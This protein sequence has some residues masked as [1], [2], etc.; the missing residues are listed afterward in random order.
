LNNQSDYYERWTHH[1]KRINID[2]RDG[3][4]RYVEASAPFGSISSLHN[5]NGGQFSNQPPSSPLSFFVTFDAQ[6]E[7]EHS[8]SLQNSVP[9]MPQ[10]S[11]HPCRS[12]VSLFRISEKGKPGISQWRGEP[13][14]AME[15]VLDVLVDLRLLRGSYHHPGIVADICYLKDGIQ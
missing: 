11:V 2:T 1:Q 5:S 9:N 13:A 12:L 14:S 3:T 10:S 7:S 8:S 15:R 4:I 6:Y